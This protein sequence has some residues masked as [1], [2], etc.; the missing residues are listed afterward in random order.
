MVFVLLAMEAR[1]LKRGNYRG[2]TI[3]R[4]IDK[5]VPEFFP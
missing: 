4:A 2:K 5:R 1:G 3:R